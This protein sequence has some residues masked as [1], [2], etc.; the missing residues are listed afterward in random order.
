MAQ[1]TKIAW[2]D[3]TWNIARGCTKVDEDCKFCYM[4]RDSLKGTRYEPKKVVRTKTVFNL[5]FKIK[6]PSKIFTSSLTDFFHE[7]CDAFRHEAWDIIKKCPQHTFQILTKRPERIAYYL[8]MRCVDGWDN[9]WLGTSVGHQ[10]GQNR[11]NWLLLSPKAKVKF[12][13]I[14]PMHGPLNLE[15]ITK[16][17]SGQSWTTNCLNGITHDEHYDLG[18]SYGDKIDWVIIG[19]ESGNDKGQYRYRPCKLEWIESIVVQ[20]KR[21]NVPVF[22]KQ[23]GTHLANELG[24]K[25]RH[26]ADPSEW[27]KHL[28]VQEFPRVSKSFQ[29]HINGQQNN[30]SKWT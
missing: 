13:S 7:D 20:C 26:G 30:Y 22:V 6:E 8:P 19:G 12:L 9:V 25:D 10:K 2:T 4:Y 14:E 3:A 28:R 15:K 1:T 18:E 27:P 21:W 17:G 23:L 11:I 29:T 5:P 16:C 24:L